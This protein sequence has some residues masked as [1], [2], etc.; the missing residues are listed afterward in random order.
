MADFRSFE[1][2]KV[3][4]EHHFPLWLIEMGLEISLRDSHA[5]S[6]Q[7]KRGILG[8]V[9]AMDPMSPPP[10][11]RGG[12]EGEAGGEDHAAAASKALAGR[13][14]VAECFAQARG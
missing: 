10:A 3:A 9:A 13:M 12:A 2:N 14:A 7:D 1:R 8:A 4:R 5:A 11:A 6:E